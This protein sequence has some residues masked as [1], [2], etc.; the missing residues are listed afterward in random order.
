MIPMLLSLFLIACGGVDAARDTSGGADTSTSEVTAEDC[1]SEEVFAN[2]CTACGPTDACTAYA[3]MCLTT[4][5]A[6]QEGQTCADGGF[7]QSGVC[8]PV[9]CG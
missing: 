6:E 7:C 2:A 1:T 9:I 3:A 4:C 8:L 5:P